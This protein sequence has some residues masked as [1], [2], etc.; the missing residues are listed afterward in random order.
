MVRP[1]FSNKGRRFGCA[2]G[3]CAALSRSINSSTSR[4]EAA[5]RLP[6]R[7]SATGV[8]NGAREKINVAAEGIPQVG[9]ILFD[10]DDT[11]IDLPQS[12]DVLGSVCRGVDA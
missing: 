1:R 10:L 3:R 5:R 6:R 2:G 4:R 7:R 11:S 8:A 12:L 9:K